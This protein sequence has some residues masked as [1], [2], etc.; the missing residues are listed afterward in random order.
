MLFNLLNHIAHILTNKRNFLV[1]ALAHKLVIDT[2]N[3]HET[4]LNQEFG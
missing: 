1:V 4:G 2:P 3:T